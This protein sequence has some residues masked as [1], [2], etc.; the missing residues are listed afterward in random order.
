MKMIKIKKKQILSEAERTYSLSTKIARN[1]FQQWKH[2]RSKAKFIYPN[3]PL[4]EMGVEEFEIVFFV[5]KMYTDGAPSM[6]AVY[7]KHKKGG[8]IAITLEIYKKDSQYFERIYNRLHQILVHELNHAIQDLQGKLYGHPWDS[9]DNPKILLKISEKAFMIYKILASKLQKDKD[10]EKLLSEMIYYLDPSEIEAY[11][12]DMYRKAQKQRLEFGEVLD[13]FIE[14]E[15]EYMIEDFEEVGQSH[16]Q[17]FVEYWELVRDKIVVYVEHYLP[18][19]IL[20]ESILWALKC[21]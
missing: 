8:R 10:R 13:D 11:S 4:K 19:A 16:P 21:S 18:K 17:L 7:H 12:R 6:S 15:L 14:S 20:K 3:N 2:S 9:Q 5:E 1:L